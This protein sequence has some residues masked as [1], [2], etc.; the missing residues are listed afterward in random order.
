MTIYLTIPI[1][2]DNG[3]EVITNLELIAHHADYFIR[4]ESDTLEV[5]NQLI[6][7]V[8]NN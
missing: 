6:Q 5:A 8:V 4:H 2:F 7:T 1:D 3:G